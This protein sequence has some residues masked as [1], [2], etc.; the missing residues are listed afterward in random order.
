MLLEDLY[1]V[2]SYGSLPLASS[3]D[4]FHLWFSYLYTCTYRW[5]WA[6]G[7]HEQ[8]KSTFLALMILLKTTYAGEVDK[9]DDVRNSMIHWEIKDKNGT[10]ANVA[11]RRGASPYLE[12]KESSFHSICEIMNYITYN[13]YRVG[14]LLHYWYYTPWSIYSDWLT[15]TLTC[16][17]L[18]AL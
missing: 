16:S 11:V 3:A 7:E 14:T 8:N 2:P 5:N 9:R 10:C 12:A 13:E 17:S 18:L 4:D 1:P 6:L 15:P